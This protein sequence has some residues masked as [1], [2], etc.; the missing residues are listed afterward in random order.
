MTLPLFSRLPCAAALLLVLLSANAQA[1]MPASI[2]GEGLPSLAPLVEQT[3]PAV[4]NI[5]TRSTVSAPRNPLMDD[6]F[7]RRFFGEQEGMQQREREVSAAGSGVIVD[8][9]KGYILTNHH[10][11]NDADEIKVFLNDDRA[12]DAVVI[13]SDAGT[14]IAV[15]QIENP[16]N[17]TA[18]QIGDS[19]KLLVGD[20]V[21]AIGN[22]F[23]LQHT[24]T[25]GI[26]SALG[27]RGIQRDGYEDF[28]QTDASINPGNSGGALINLRG[29]LV[30]IN[31]AIYSQSGGNIG[32]GFA[33][34]VS[35]AASIMDQ[36]LEFGEVKRGLLGVSIRDFSAETAEALGMDPENYQGALIEEIF[37]D[38]PAEKAGLEVGDVITLVDGQP[39]TSAGDL[40]TT[41]GLKRS[42]EK[43]RV[44][45]MRQSKT[46]RFTATLGEIDAEPEL[47]AGEIHPGL[48]GAEFANYDGS[49]Q[50]HQGKGVLISSV[51]PGSPAEFRG[52]QT[53]DVITLVNQQA[54][55]SVSE[56]QKL[57]EDQSLLVLKI[58]RGD[59][60]LLRTIR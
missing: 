31:S 43:V 49:S 44:T 37:P 19:E 60:T 4:V 46:L 57:A 27:R 21:V 58:H 25:S 36:I 7:F 54:V 28:I 23:G 24:V 55:Q 14:D 42:G 32:I 10:V 9:K 56:L 30:G 22:P 15:I 8:A 40:R 41:I 51:A 11:V 18:M 38:S 47:V 16:E 20:F 52:L 13:G 2:N 3:A 12:F 6:P 35:I 39:V 53:N 48:A 45:V 34:P 26:V 29:E 50:P 5:R 33:I 1:A 17:L 59:R